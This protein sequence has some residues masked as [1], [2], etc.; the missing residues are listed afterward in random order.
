MDTTHKGSGLAALLAAMVLIHLLLSLWHGA[1]HTQ[2]P[3]PLS[4]AQQAFVGLIIILLPVV[5]A[6]LL[7][8]R[9]RRPAALLIG[10]TMLASLI[11]GFLNHFVLDSADNVVSVPEH[12]WRHSF[13]VSAAV[14]AIS[15][16]ATA[17][18]AAIAAWTWNRA[19]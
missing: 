4:G 17:V 11:F 1:A 3:V 18:L 8:S 10:A 2:V 9:R 13:V 19:A 16:S 7:W 14:I 6:A 5:G 12:V 15:E